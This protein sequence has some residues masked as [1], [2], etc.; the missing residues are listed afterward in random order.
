MKIIKQED[1]KDC[2]LCVIQYFIKKYYKKEV[3]IDILKFNCNYGVDGIN[4]S[5]LKDL[6][7]LNNLEMES[8][9]GDFKSLTSINNESLPI[10]LL[11][12]NNGLTHYVVLE[13]IKNNYFYIQDSSIGKRKVLKGKDLEKIFCGIIATFKRSSIKSKPRLRQLNKFSDFFSLNRFAYMLF[14]M[15]IIN[16]MLLFSSTFFVKIVFDYILPNYL[17]E[18][19]TLLFLV[20]IWLNIVRFI[21][22]YLKSYLT[23]KISNSIEIEL[24]DAFFNVLQNTSKKEL[25]KLKTSDYYKRTMYIQPI[26]EYQANFVYTLIS[27]LFSVAFSICILIWINLI[28]F[29]VVFGILFLNTIF[30]IIYYLQIESK[31]SEL[32]QS[33]VLKIQADIDLINIAD[34]FRTDSYKNY[35]NNYHFKNFYNLK[36]IEQEFFKKENIKKLLNNLLIGNLTII[37]VYAAGLIFFKNSLSPGKLIMFLTCMNFFVNPVESIS[38]LFIHQSL[39]KRNIEQV[40]FVLNLK[41]NLPIN[42]GFKLKKIK[43]I[44]INKMNFGYLKNKDILNINNWKIDSNIQI[45]GNNGSGK[46]TLMNALC[47]Q[48]G[49]NVLKH[50]SINNINF[51]S[52]NS[53]DYQKNIIYISNSQ[54]IPNIPI[55]DFITSNETSQL[56]TLNNNI[57]KYKLGSIMDQ[58]NFSLN[59]NVVN[60]ASNLSAGQ[61]QLLNLF[62]LFSKQYKLIMLDEAFENIDNKVAKKIK[63]YIKSFQKDSM[64][65]EVSHNNNYIFNNKEVIFEKFNKSK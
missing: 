51:E 58:L 12:N 48:F 63:K 52:I 14:L 42:K 8:Y 20:F 61:R 24:K 15:S 41:T 13:K 44:Q 57:A 19:L 54:Y 25:S 50:V 4:L 64:F 26:A 37:V 53:K 40:N 59:G 33:N 62:K 9:S 56:E 30:N 32:I 34:H 2:G 27:E 21:N 60:N 39:M 47:C 5:E 7:L 46:T 65:I 28:L 43:C 45:K 17:K 55:I 35:L 11:V 18:E 36:L 23:K 6:A 29:L 31:Y 16:L 1:E 49:I 10:M 38:S 3:D 22:S